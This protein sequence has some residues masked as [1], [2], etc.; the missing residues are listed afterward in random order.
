MRFPFSLSIATGAHIARNLLAGRRRFSMVLMLE[1][2]HACNLRC[3]GC[4][5]IREYPKTIGQT[6]TVEECLAA[7]SQCGAPIVSVCG[8]EPLLYKELPELLDRLLDAGKHIYLCTNGQILEESI[9]KL[10]S[11]KSKRL[12]KRCYLNVHLDG[13][14]KVHDQVVEKV[15]AFDRALAGIRAAK[16]SGFRLYTNTTVYAQTTVDDLIDMAKTL[17]AENIDGLMISPAYGY[18]AVKAAGTSAEALFMDRP[19]IEAFF[20]EVRRRMGGYRL[21]ATPM[22]FDFLTGQRKLS[23]AAWANPTRNVAGWRSPCYL[24]GDAHFSTYRELLEKTDWE[25]IGPGR[26]ERCR[27][28]MTHCGFEPASVLAVKSPAQIVRVALWQL[29]SKR[30]A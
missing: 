29:W 28:C 5:R 9:P 27:D 19:R 14:A 15:G 6:M 30:R 4:G 10:L 23:C 18:E 16:K 3:T 17:S 8:G 2:L 21:T 13:P 7:A 22:F 25:K 1:P 11:V 12:K 24:I 20:R 26:D